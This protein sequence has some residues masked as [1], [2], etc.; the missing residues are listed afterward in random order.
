MY[1]TTH[2]DDVHRVVTSVGDKEVTAGSGASEGQ[3]P[4]EV[5]TT[6]EQELHGR[7]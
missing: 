2:V 6:D 1:S 5:T 7:R 3:V 4:R